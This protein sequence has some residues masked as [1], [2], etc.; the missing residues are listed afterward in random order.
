MYDLRLGICRLDRNR[1]AREIVASGVHGLGRVNAEGKGKCCFSFWAE[2]LWYI[3]KYRC[4]GLWTALEIGY[5]GWWYIPIGHK[6]TANLVAAIIVFLA[7]KLH[8]GAWKYIVQTWLICRRHL[9]SLGSVRVEDIEWLYTCTWTFQ[10]T[11][12]QCKKLI[13]PPHD[14]TLS[15]V[16]VCGLKTY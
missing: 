1:R 14:I 11:S 9:D 7:P 3:V 8:P 10:G 15:S 13:T 2:T 4:V 6:S 5:T 12:A 16:L